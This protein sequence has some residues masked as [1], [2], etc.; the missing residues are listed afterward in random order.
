MARGI[1]NAD[2]AK[3]IANKVEPAHMKHYG[4]E[5]VSI[6][7]QSSLKSAV[8]VTSNW[9]KIQ[10]EV[11]ELKQLTELTLLVAE[12]FEKWVTR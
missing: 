4:N 11:L 6:I 2:L 3:K 1:Q 9:Y 12:E 8:E 10:D 5:Q 7:R